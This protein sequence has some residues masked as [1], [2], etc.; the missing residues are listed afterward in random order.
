MY[1]NFY[2]GAFLDRDG[3]INEDNYYV[4][5]KRNFI[6]KNG[7]FD[8]LRNLTKN[9]FLIFIITNQSGIARGYFTEA[10]YNKI[11][12]YYKSILMSEGIKI[13]AIYHCPHHPD[14]SKVPFDNCDCRKPKPG[15][16]LKAKEKYN[17][18]MKESIAIGDSLRDLQAAYYASIKK[19]ILLSTDNISSEFITH[20]FANI[21]ECS[22][23]LFDS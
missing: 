12:K 21:K 8:L 18:N 3:V 14:F 9:N 2:K 5:E 19:R 4:Y 22:K 7:I 13:K 23:N 1:D 15:L 6:F 20:R 10:Q 17:I 11:T 16:F